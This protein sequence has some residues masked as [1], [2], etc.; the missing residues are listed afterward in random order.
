MAEWWE[1]ADRS[2]TTGFDLLLTPTMANPPAPLGEIRGDDADE[3][4]HHRL[5]RTLRFTGHRST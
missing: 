3:R 4:G 5:R 1:P 2:D